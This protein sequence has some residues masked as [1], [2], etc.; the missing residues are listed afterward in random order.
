LLNSIS[1]ITKEITLELKKLN[2]KLKKQKKREKETKSQFQ[3]INEIIDF[4]K[5]LE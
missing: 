4:Y 1:S 5:K 3:E 2:T